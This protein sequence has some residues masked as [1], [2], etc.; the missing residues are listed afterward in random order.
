MIAGRSLTTTAFAH[1]VGTKTSSHAR[2]YGHSVYLCQEGG[3]PDEACEV[4]RF[5]VI[6][7]GGSAESFE[8]VEEAFDDVAVAISLAVVAF[9]DAS[10]ADRLDA[11]LGVQLFDAG[12]NRV[13]VVARIGDD[14]SDLVRL[15]LREQPVRLRGVV[16]RAGRE[17]ESQQSAAAIDGR[18]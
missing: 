15:E 5:F 4:G 16:A 18:M 17:G 6:T 1:G 12:A 10:R 7:G 3:E 14:V 9:L 8:A 2:E 11:G 13:A